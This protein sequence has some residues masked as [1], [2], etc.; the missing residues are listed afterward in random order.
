MAAVEQW[1]CALGWLQL[2]Q[3]KGLTLTTDLL[4]QRPTRRH[5]WLCFSENYYIFVSYEQVLN[6]IIEKEKNNLF[7]LLC[8][9][10]LI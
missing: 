10:P 5:F 4:L 1:Q 7:V 6:N 8:Y 2:C 9:L 3:G